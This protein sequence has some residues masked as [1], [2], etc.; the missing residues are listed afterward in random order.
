MDLNPVGG[1]ELQKVA[2]ASV[3]IDDAVVKRVKELIAIKDLQE[4]PAQAKG[5]EKK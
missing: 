3:A 2:Q 5:G 1:A 4:A